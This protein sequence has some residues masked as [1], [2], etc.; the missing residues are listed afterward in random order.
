[1]YYYA[2]VSYFSYHRLWYAI[3][4]LII[5]ATFVLSR[6]FLLMSYPVCYQVM[7]LL[8]INNT[9]AGQFMTHWIEKLK[10]LLDAFQSPFKDK[11]HLTAGMYFLY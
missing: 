11:Y 2:A 10:P 9:R 7:A 4:A 3:P 5:L 6:P 8:R 1:M